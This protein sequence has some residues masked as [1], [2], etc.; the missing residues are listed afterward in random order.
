MTSV[1]ELVSSHLPNHRTSGQ[2]WLQFNAVCCHHRG[3][4]PDSRNRGNI[5]FSDGGKITYSCFNCGFA[6]I[7]DPRGLT[8]KFQKLMSWLGVSQDEIRDVK[9][10]QLSQQLE[11]IESVEEDSWTWIRRDF[12]Q[13]ELPVGAMPLKHWQNIQ[14]QDPNYIRV[15]DYINSRSGVSGIL[16]DSYEYYWTPNTIKDMNQ[17]L[18]VPFWYHGRCVAWTARWAGTPFNPAVPRYFNSPLPVGFLFGAEHLENRSRKFALVY[19]G[20][21]DAISGSGV[22]VL[23]SKF[24]REQ[25]GWLKSSGKEIIVVPDRQSQNQDLIDSAIENGF[26]VSFPEW[27]WNIKDMADAVSKYGQLFSI[28]TIIES[29]SNN[30]LEIGVRRQRLGKA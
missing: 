6:V 3:H 7:Y 21:F 26:G 18:I 13:I 11:G 10:H 15:H 29:A 9:L 1:T 5:R 14:C 12:E 30:A 24:S 17:R 4:K 27:E 2:G 19:E 20:P 25:I 28:K 22:A 23:G 16:K 8:N